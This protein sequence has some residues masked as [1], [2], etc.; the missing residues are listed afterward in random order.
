MRAKGYLI[1]TIIP[2]IFFPALF[3]VALTLQI[4][5]FILNFSINV[6]LVDDWL[7]V[8][9][10]YDFNFFNFNENLTLINGHQHLLI[11]IYLFLFDTFF[12][13]SFSKSAIIAVILFSL[14]C[15]LLILSSLH[16]LNL[17]NL[18]Y[19]LVFSGLSLLGLTFRQGQN[20][21]LLICF[22]WCLSFFLIG[23]YCYMSSRN[24]KINVIVRS[25]IIFIAPMSNGLGLVVPVAI[26]IKMF[27]CILLKLKISVRLTVSTLL[28]LISIFISYIYPSIFLGDNN[29][30]SSLNL[31]SFIGQL[32]VS[33]I[34]FLKFAFVSV[35]QP[36]LTWNP[37]QIDKGIFITIFL[38]LLF[39]WTLRD[40]KSFYMNFF[41]GNNYLIYGFIYFIILLVMRSQPLGVSGS[42]EPRYTTSALL[43]LIP[44]LVLILS[45]IERRWI[46]LSAIFIFLSS[47]YAFNIGSKVGKDYYFFRYN[48]YVEMK[49][50]FVN[51]SNP[52]SNLNLSPE[53]IAL[54]IKQS[55]GVNEY[56][57]KIYLQG[58]YIN[59]N[60]FKE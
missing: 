22:P 57:L 7:L 49:T 19:I 47:L 2:R 6:P 5:F 35:S 27:Y 43:F 32:F 16:N 44:F 55:E 48:Q 31:F 8:K 59:Q 56:E 25:L 45:N 38:L 4:I 3:H 33:P 58:L 39:S 60:I 10:I 46:T 1:R 18:N 24:I 50:C 11:R 13:F 36:Y 29:Q 41:N 21:F 12:G 15:F 30:N 20:F 17:S 51:E 26:I 53:C 40:K 37:D 23:L 52:S 54:F 14:G 34:S 9:N 28:S 42:L